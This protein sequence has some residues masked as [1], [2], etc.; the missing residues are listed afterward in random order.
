MS[1]FDK[2]DAIRI[3]LGL[4]LLL[5]NVGVY[6]GVVLEESS[7][8]W[9]KERGKRLLRLSLAW[10]AVLALTLFV[11]DTTASVIQKREIGELYERAANA[12]LEL[13][14]IKIPRKIDDAQYA[15]LVE[16]LQMAPK[17]PIYVIGGL[18][19]L[20]APDLAKRISSALKSAGFSDPPPWNGGGKGNN[21]RIILSWDCPGLVFQV[22]NLTDELPHLAAV[23]HCMGALKM[24]M[25]ERID[26]EQ[27][28]GTFTIG[29]GSRL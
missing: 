22:N 10:E 3:I 12:E 28:E 21:G 5:C 29:I 25:T 7:Y 6:R 1:A 20:D 17:G 4:G 14:K 11:A 8:D 18:S 27:P 19:D 23:S 26:D 13:A 15:A 16:C 2:W 24:P 9:T